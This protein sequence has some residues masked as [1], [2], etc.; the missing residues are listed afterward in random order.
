MNNNIINDKQSHD[1]NLQ[2]EFSLS[3]SLDIKPGVLAQSVANFDIDNYMLVSQKGV[4]FDRRNL[5]LW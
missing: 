3:P 5:L 1:E 2:E 4:V